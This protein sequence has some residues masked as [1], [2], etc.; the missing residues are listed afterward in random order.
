MQATTDGYP[1]GFLTSRPCLRAAG[2]LV[3]VGAVAA[4]LSACGANFAGKNTGEPD[5]PFNAPVGKVESQ[6]LEGAAPGSAGNTIGT[7]P[8][9]VALILPLTSPNG[10]PSLV[11]QSLR[12]AADLA[13]TESGSTNLTIL[14]KDDHSSPDGARDAAQA[15]L[16]EGA[17]LFI[18]PL[19]AG[20]VRE[21]AR[22][23]RNAGKPLIA[24]S[25]DSTTAS[26]GSWLLSFLIE[27]YVDRI[28]DYAAAKGKKSMAAL[29]PDNDYGRVAEAEFQAEA[30]RKN[31]RVQAIEHYTPQTL[32]ASIKR[33]AAVGP[34][35][36][37]LFIPE[38][39]D[40]MTAMS[41][42]LVANGID[43]KRIQ[44]LGT[45]LWNDAR[46]LNLPGLQGA[47]FAAPENDGFNRFA[48]RYRAKYGVDPTRLA[49]LA[50]DAVSLAAALAK[51]QGSQR[52]SESVLLNK[53]GFNGADGVFRFRPDGLNDRGLAVLQINNGTA[54]PVSPAPRNF[55]QS[56]AM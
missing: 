31:I 21:A 54:A 46:V 19:F 23:A 22:V 52:F 20:D 36:D 10:Q 4:F 44:I 41:A 34:Q 25:T 13:L 48:Q 8:V 18:G 47:W 40:A 9:K 24:F 45:G 15:A 6:P 32:D 37:S 12:N 53:A 14:V 1:S 56:S 5:L 55:A 16:A 42:T 49:T 30:A 26:R 38:Q 33:I 35:I 17:E 50:Y 51:T 11:G 2:R 39:A 43:G 7:G 29:I 3:I 27:S 28:V